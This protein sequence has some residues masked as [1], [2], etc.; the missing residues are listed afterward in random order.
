MHPT[1]LPS[2]K[3]DEDATD[4]LDF[5]AEAGISVWQTLPL[6]VP[7]TGGSPYQCDSAFAIN[8]TLVPEDYLAEADYDMQAFL[9]W[10][11]K[12]ACW[13]ED[14]ALFA[15]LKIHFDKQAWFEWPAPYR[16]RSAAALE[17]FGKQHADVIRSI[18]WQQFRVYSRWCEIHKYARKRGIYLFGD[19]PIFVAHDSSDV[20]AHPDYFLLDE[21]GQPTVVAGVPPDYFSETG[22][23]WGNPH[24]NWEVLEANGFDWWLDRLRAHF[25]WFDIVRIDHFR[26]L[27]AVWT[28]D[29]DCDTAIDGYWQSV[30]GDQLLARFAAE[31]GQPQLVAEDL[32]VITPEV[33]ALRDKYHLPGMA[34]LQFSFDAFEDNP[35]KPKNIKP[36]TVVYTGTHDNDTTQGWFD[37]LQEHEQQHVMSQIGAQSPA[38]IVDTMINLALGTQANLAVVPLQ[39]FL[40]LGSEAR[41]NTPGTIADNWQWRCRHEQ[42]G[43]DFAQQIRTKL[44]DYGR[45]GQ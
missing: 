18:K 39:D 15:S 19:M 37:A 38:Q 41:M 42:L 27:E 20:W 11:R 7:Q 3:L 40:G 33:V 35:H 28:I 26:G 4:W 9:D 23:R 24:Y 43:S 30:P 21:A 6:G 2:G 5:L 44:A 25:A 45:L 12:Q 36:N 22:Q 17:R 13:L 29:R 10:E 14:Y 34:V 31:E 8:P 32:G 1:S 16:T